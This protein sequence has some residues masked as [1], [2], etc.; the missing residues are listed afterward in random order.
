M[1]PLQANT[2]RN[3]GIRANWTDPASCMSRPIQSRCVAGIPACGEGFPH[4]QESKTQ[5]PR[6][7]TGPHCAAL[8]GGH[9]GNSTD[10]GRANPAPSLRPKVR[11]VSAALC[12]VVSAFTPTH[13][14]ADSGRSGNCIVEQA[15]F[16]C[17]LSPENI[18]IANYAM[19]PD[20]GRL[21]S[22]SGD[23][24]RGQGRWKFDHFG[25]DP[26]WR[27][28]RIRRVGTLND[29]GQISDQWKWADRNSA[30]VADLIGRS[31]SCI[32]N[33]DDC[34]RAFGW[35]KDLSPGRLIAR[36]RIDGVSD[37]VEADCINIDKRTHL[38]T[39]GLFL[40]V[41]YP[42][43]QTSENHQE[44]RQPSDDDISDL[45]FAYKVFA[46]FALGVWAFACAIS[47]RQIYI[48]AESRLFSAVAVL[49]GLSGPLCAFCGFW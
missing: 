39:G 37:I 47:G 21:V 15:I 38:P 22:D 25:G 9:R 7:A 17:P 8:G 42:D 34:K 32:F 5:A 29:S 48:R 16:R 18:A 27:E 10:R 12:G 36:Q 35:G 2:P 24:S 45:A 49:I 6:L 23:L 41:A 20:C 19:N 3:N 46:P 31:I 11:P 44:K 30:K 43:Q 40:S 26:S 28:G 4:E 14:S 1:A 13:L 33:P